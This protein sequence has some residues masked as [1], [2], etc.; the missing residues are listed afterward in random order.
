[1]STDN[2]DHPAGDQTGE[3]M[4]QKAL[5][6][7]RATDALPT[8]RSVL[9]VHDRRLNPAAGA[10]LA[11]AEPIGTRG[12]RSIR[13]TFI[14]IVGLRDALKRLWAS[15]REE[16]S[17]RVT[18]SCGVPVVPPPDERRYR[19]PMSDAQI[20]NRSRD[21]SNASIATDEFSRP[22]IRA[23]SAPRCRFSCA[24]RRRRPFRHGTSTLGSGGVRPPRPAPDPRV[25]VGR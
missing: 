21:S 23:R 17:E 16:L 22:R 20:E 12:G 13:A 3:S 11:N 18:D 25:G 24:F 10:R 8:F 15:H 4:A 5:A 19:Y 9:T 14:R 1:M 2:L 7:R 6:R